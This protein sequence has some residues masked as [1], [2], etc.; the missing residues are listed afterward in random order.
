[1]HEGTKVS[2]LKFWN[3]NPTA[4]VHESWPIFFTN[5]GETGI[6]VPYKKE[7]FGT[8]CFYNTIISRTKN[9]RKPGRLFQFK[10]MEGYEQKRE[11]M[12]KKQQPPFPVPQF[13]NSERKKKNGTPEASPLNIVTHLKL[14]A[15][16][17]TKQSERSLK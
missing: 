2:K 15:M 17:G 8:A 6:L 13:W 11:L 7:E 5:P 4:C 12:M 14:K 1:M 3:Q 9:Y 10:S 16:A